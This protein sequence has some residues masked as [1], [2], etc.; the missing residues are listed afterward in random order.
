METDATKAELELR[1]IRAERY[2]LLCSYRKELRVMY[3]DLAFCLAG[4]GFLL[5]SFFML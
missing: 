1:E 5:L 4:F 2:L 3:F